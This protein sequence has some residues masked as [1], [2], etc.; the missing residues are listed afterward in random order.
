MY[1]VIFCGGKQQKVSEG[2]VVSVDLL[3]AQAGT[4]IEL[5]KVLCLEQTVKHFLGKHRYRLHTVYS[6][7]VGSIFCFCN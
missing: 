2:D 4:D 7:I 3:D 5:D 1:A 6:V